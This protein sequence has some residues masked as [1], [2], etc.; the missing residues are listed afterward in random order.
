MQWWSVAGQEPWSW[1]WRPYPGV[2]AL[3][4]LLVLWHRRIVRAAYPDGVPA[5]GRQRAYFAA[6]VFCLWLGLDWPLGALGASYLVSIH[7]VQFLLIGLVAPVFLLMGT[8]PD[9]FAG[10]SDRP[11]LLRA[12]EG[13]TQP[14]VAFFVFNVGMTVTHWPEV[15]DFLMASQLGSFTLDMTWLIC[16]LILWW[17][18]VAPVPARPDFHPLMQILYLAVNAILIR[19]PFLM[20]IFAKYPIYATYELAP[21]IAGTDPL[22]DQQVAGGIMKIGSAWI[23]ILGVIL[24]FFEWVKASQQEERNA[25]R[26]VRGD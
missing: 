11:R 9:A 1:A 16:G 2:W 24:L 22:A 5:G 21:P 8:P 26:A 25:A 14:I 19:P 17:P 12:V 4:V 6:G 10:L 13:V 18:V 23:L 3:I 15:T 20:M 7:M